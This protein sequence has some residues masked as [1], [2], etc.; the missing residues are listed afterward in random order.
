MI[1]VLGNIAL[2]AAALASADSPPSSPASATGTPPAPATAILDYYPAKA[3]AAGQ[4]G[5]VKLACSSN[6][7]LRPIDCSLASEDPPGFGFGDA[8][9]AMAKLAKD[10]LEVTTR[11]DPTPREARFYF[12]AKPPAIS[13]D[14]LAPNA[15]VFPMWLR[16]P[17]GEDIARVYPR[18]A[19]ELNLGGQVVLRC[20]FGADGRMAQCAVA[21]ENPVRLGFGAAALSLAPKFQMPFNPGG[22]TVTIPIR[23]IAP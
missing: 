18:A 2:L 15:L 6:E 8:A 20:Q 5:I 21:D 17:S 7:H 12:T 4:S 19:G 23:F 11:P 13:P 14:L 16:K 3:L 1:S 9:L 10:H 22:V